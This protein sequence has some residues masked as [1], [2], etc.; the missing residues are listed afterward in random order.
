MT[1]YADYTTTTSSNV[2][3]VNAW[4]FVAYVLSHYDEQMDQLVYA[5]PFLYA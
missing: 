2:V 5:S 3:T 1:D 4:R